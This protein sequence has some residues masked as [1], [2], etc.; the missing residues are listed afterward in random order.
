MDTFGYFIWV[1]G[2]KGPQPQKVFALPSA[3]ASDYWS[4]KCG[5]IL[6]VHELSEVNCQMSLDELSLCFPQPETSKY[7]EV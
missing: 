5:R 4:D 2:Q 7:L 3:V 1:F 6:A